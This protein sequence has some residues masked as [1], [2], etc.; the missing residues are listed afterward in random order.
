MGINTRNQLYAGE[1]TPKW[2]KIK[3]FMIFFSSCKAYALHRKNV[4]DEIFKCQA[5]LWCNCQPLSG[6]SNSYCYWFAIFSYLSYWKEVTYVTESHAQN[7]LYMSHFHNSHNQY[8]WCPTRCRS[9]L[10]NQNYCVWLYSSFTYN[11]FI[12]VKNILMTLTVKFSPLS[13]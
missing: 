3:D 1:I 11:I 4:H 2:N 12:V 5:S 10:G 7:C 8:P 6:T 9:F 13:W